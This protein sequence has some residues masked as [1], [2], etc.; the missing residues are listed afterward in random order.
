MFS[1][2]CHFYGQVVQLSV[3]QREV[4]GISKQKAIKTQS[5]CALVTIGKY[6]G[7]R[8]VAKKVSCFGC[9][10]GVALVSK[11]ALIWLCSRR[12]KKVYIPAGVALDGLDIWP[13]KGNAVIMRPFDE[14]RRQ[15]PRYPTYRQAFSG[16]GSI[17]PQSVQREPCLRLCG[18]V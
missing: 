17:W 3:V 14:R 9:E 11:A 13:V 1:M 2:G 15:A 7:G 16:P 5:S 18:A 12:M 6:V 10:R 4:K 8:E